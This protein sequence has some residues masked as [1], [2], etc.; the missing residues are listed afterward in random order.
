MQYALVVA[1]RQPIG[2]PRRLQHRRVAQVLGRLEL[3]RALALG[4]APVDSV[5]HGPLQACLERHGIGG[6]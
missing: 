4:T 5:L 1:Q 2:P 6:R 3:P